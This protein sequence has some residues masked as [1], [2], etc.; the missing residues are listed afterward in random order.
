MGTR[1]LVGFVIDGEVKATYNHSDSY[2]EGVGQDVLD[3]ART[4]NEG[5][6]GKARAIVLVDE[7]DTPTPEQKAH[8]SQYANL[9][10]ST[11]SDEDWYCLLRSAQGD[12]QAYLDAGV[13]IDNQDFGQDSLFCE[14]GYLVNLDETKLEVYKGFQTE[15]H[16]DGRFANMESMCGYETAS[17]DTYQPIRLVA[18]FPLSGLPADL[19]DAL[20]A[21]GVLER[22]DA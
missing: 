12:L 7:Q 19:A 10:V 2:P 9:G 11:R 22:E 21:E 14:W 15:P 3:F 1:G 4:V 20:M 5:T 18:E 17:G 8:L 6:P 16:T 13:M